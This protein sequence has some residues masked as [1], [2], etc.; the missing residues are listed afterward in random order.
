[1]KKYLLAL[2]VAVAMLATACG[3][4]GGGG[5]DTSAPTDP[6][7]QQIL[8]LLAE[9]EDFPLSEAEANCTANNMLANLDSSTIDAMLANPD[10]DMTDVGDP[11]E[12]VVAIDA[13]LDCVDV[14][15]L[16][17][18]SMT[19]DGTPT[20]QAECMAAAFGEDEIRAFMRSAALPEDQV[21]EE[22]A[23]ELFATIMSAALDCGLG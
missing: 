6:R 23:S 2:T 3:D 9:D 5:G 20:D 15:Q 22:A 10:G 11:G 12:A 16:M 17:I 21:D 8:E 4:D 1:M 18:Q 14:E 13:L 19:A 7:G